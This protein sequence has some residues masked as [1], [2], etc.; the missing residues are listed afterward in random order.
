MTWDPKPMRDHAPSA[1]DTT[2]Q[3]EG[4]KHGRLV[5]TTHVQDN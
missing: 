5:V 4:V 2:A 3:L 1:L